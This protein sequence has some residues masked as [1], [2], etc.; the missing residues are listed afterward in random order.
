MFVFLY[1]LLYYILGCEWGKEKGRFPLGYLAFRMYLRGGSHHA[2]SQT[3]TATN[4]IMSMTFC[5]EI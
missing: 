2:I 1:T 5:S 4:A 3:E